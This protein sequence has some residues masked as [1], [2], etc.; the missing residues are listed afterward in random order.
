MYGLRQ[1]G[2]LAYILLTKHLQLHGYA[3]SGFTT[4][5]FKHATRDTMFSLVFGEFGVKYTAKNDA[6][7]LIKTLK[8][9]YPGITIDWSGRIF[10]GIHLDW[11]CTKRT[12]TI[13]IP[14]Y[15]NKALPIFQH[16]KLNTTNIHHIRTEHQTMAPRSN[17][18]LPVQLLI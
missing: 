15:V 6:F 7:H 10:L 3:C 1:L 14:N 13:S 5:L 8:K 11:D 16:K 18:H 12:I 2:R 9:K 4:G 17:M